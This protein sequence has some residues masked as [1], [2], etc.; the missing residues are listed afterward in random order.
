MV[1]A[2]VLS[3][4]SPPELQGPSHHQGDECLYTGRVCLRHIGLEVKCCLWLPFPELL[5]DECL[6]KDTEKNNIALTGRTEETQTSRIYLN[7]FYIKE[8]VS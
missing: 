4:C 7:Y 2:T 3:F 1:V 6:N 5:K 8:L